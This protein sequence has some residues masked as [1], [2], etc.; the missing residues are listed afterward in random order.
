MPSSREACCSRRPSGHVPSSAILQVVWGRSLGGQQHTHDDGL[1]Q[2]TF[3]S[4]CR[5][6]LV[7]ASCIILWCKWQSI[8]E[9]EQGGW[10]DLLTE[11]MAP[12]VSVFLVSTGGAVAATTTNIN[13]LLLPAS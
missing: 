13:L 9:E 12:S 3:P 8:D 2:H 6:I 7:N 11:G 10:K 4:A 1:K 5:A